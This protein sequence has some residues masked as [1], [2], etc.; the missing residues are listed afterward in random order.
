MK[1]RR[2]II[3]GLFPI[4]GILGGAFVL[5]LYVTTNGHVEV[6]SIDKTSKSNKDQ[7]EQ[8]NTGVDMNS[9]LRVATYGR[10]QEESKN[11]NLQKNKHI[12]KGE[13]YRGY[14]DRV[15]SLLLEIDKPLSAQEEVIYKT[16]VEEANNFAFSDYN[17]YPVE[18][19]KELSKAGDAYASRALVNRV[20]VG[21]AE[22]YAKKSIK[23]GHLMYSAI[24][25]RLIL[26]TETRP[27]AYA[28]LLLGKKHGDMISK[29]S[30]RVHLKNIPTT[31]DEFEEAIDYVPSLEQEISE[32]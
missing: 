3:H 24:A 12:N 7:M 23:A 13:L 17:V 5:Y 29:K 11:T 26:N 30:L 31:E 25:L 20:P 22:K 2:F 15:R 16:Q 6:D 28:Y 4:V 14:S 32:L 18:S 1:K 21:E 10:A 9:E 19:L 8:Y 27:K